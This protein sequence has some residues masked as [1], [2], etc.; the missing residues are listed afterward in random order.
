MTRYEAF[1]ALLS[2]DAA[3][4]TYQR[5]SLLTQ[6]GH[7]DRRQWWSGQPQVYS[8]MVQSDRDNA[9]LRVASVCT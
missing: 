5:R 3:R 6:P 1:V 4:D 7:P 2:G 9:A 8:A